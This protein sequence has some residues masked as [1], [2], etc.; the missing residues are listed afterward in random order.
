[1]NKKKTQI[2]HIAKSK[3]VKRNKFQ[4]KETNKRKIIT[5]HIFLINI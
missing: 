5:S 3:Y 2:Y 4:I 1:M